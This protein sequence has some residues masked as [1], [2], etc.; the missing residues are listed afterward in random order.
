MENVAVS[1]L[2]YG[3]N[4]KNATHGIPE[5]ANI[6][7]SYLWLDLD[8]GLPRRWFKKV[9]LLGRWILNRTWCNV[10]V[11][12]HSGI[13]SLDAAPHILGLWHRTA[14][15]RIHGFPGM[16]WEFCVAF[17]SSLFH[18]ISCGWLFC[19]WR[20]GDFLR[21]SQMWCSTPV[22]TSFGAFLVGI[23]C[24]WCFCQLLGCV[25]IPPCASRIPLGHP[26]PN[27]LTPTIKHP[28]T[29]QEERI[30]KCV[31]KIFG[32]IR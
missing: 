3:K 16:A 26:I 21:S 28:A 5:L 12:Y 14:L 25:S 20:D 22:P 23:W 13:N 8:V 6:S 24:P 1:K 18:S 9:I 11:E 32:K 19:F 27:V 2:I 29:F 31:W 17:C 30:T 4:P 15:E 7:E 10:L